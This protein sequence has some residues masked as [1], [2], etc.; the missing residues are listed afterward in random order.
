MKRRDMKFKE[1]ACVRRARR[2]TVVTRAEEGNDEDDDGDVERAGDVESRGDE[3]AATRRRGVV[4]I[5]DDW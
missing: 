1:N 5:G 3:E 2:W 4:V